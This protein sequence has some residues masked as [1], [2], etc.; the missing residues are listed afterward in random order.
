MWARTFACFLFLEQCLAH[1]IYLIS[2]HKMN[3][4]PYEVETIF[5]P[6]YR[7]V[8]LRLITKLSVS[9]QLRFSTTM[10]DFYC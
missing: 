2:I 10:I 1:C 8:K 5:H 6:I 7:A 4:Q 9:S 3:I